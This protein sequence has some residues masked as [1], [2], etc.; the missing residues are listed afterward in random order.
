MSL[1]G[2]LTVR[3]IVSRSVRVRGSAAAGADSCTA[4][5]PTANAAVRW[6]AESGSWRCATRRGRALVSWMLAI[7]A[8]RMLPHDGVGVVQQGD[9]RLVVHCS[10]VLDSQNGLESCRDACGPHPGPVGQNAVGTATRSKEDGEECAH[11]ETFGWWRFHRKVGKT[12]AKLKTRIDSLHRFLY[13]KNSTSRSITVAT[14]SKRTHTCGAL[15]AGIDRN[16]GHTERVG[17]CPPGSWRC[18]FHRLPRPLRENAGRVQSAE[19]CRCVPAG[20]GSE[21][22]VRDR[23]LRGR[24][25]APGRDRE[26][27]PP[28]R[29]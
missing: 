4:V 21:E 9:Q 18:H 13:I 2:V 16:A 25:K 14:F 5:C 26:S 3:E 6:T 8:H 10:P 12:R 19:Q 22:R 11:G 24:G 7:R 29:A 17:R 23:R 15:R 20:Q 27:G 1:S 28:D